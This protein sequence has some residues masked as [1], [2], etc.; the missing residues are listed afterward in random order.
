MPY[1]VTLVLL[2]LALVWI[3]T[4]A[5]DRQGL[6][7]DPKLESVASDG[8]VIVWESPV[9]TLGRVEYGLSD[10]LGSSVSESEAVRQHR[11]VLQG[12]EP[13]TRYYFR[14]VSG[15]TASRI[16][17]FATPPAPPSFHVEPYLQLP[18]P[19]SVTIMWETT[20][21]LPG[22]VEYG[23]TPELGLTAYESGRSRLH[24]V[25]LTGLKPATTY[26]YRVVSGELA[27]GVHSFRSAPP[28]GTSRWRMALYGDSRSNPAVHRKVVEQIA[29]HQVDIIVHT[30]DIVANG[31]NYA[32]WR[33]EWFVP[34]QP[35]APSV[36]WISTIGNHEADAE[37]Y[38]S[39][40]AL[41]GNERFFA[42]DFANARFFCLD[43]NAWIEKGRDSKQYQWLQEALRQPRQAQWAFAVFHHPL[44][45]GHRTRPINPLRWDWAPLL[46]D[47]EA[48]L[49]G[50]LT[51]HDHFYARCFPIGR[52][53]EPPSHAPLFLTSAGGGAPL[54]PIRQRDY[55]A[56]IKSV[57]HFVLFEFEDDR[58]T[59]SAIDI[60]GQVF[61]RHVLTKDLPPAHLL[62]AY[63]VEEFKEFL[64]KALAAMPPTVIQGPGPHK[65]ATSLEVPT[66]FEVPLSGRLLWQPTD[67]WFFRA[68]EIPFHLQPRQTLRIPLEAVVEARG[69][70]QTPQLVIEFD[71]GRFRN[72][73]VPVFPFKL[74][75][76]ATVEARPGPRPKLDG[77]PD[78]AGW[79]AAPAYPLVAA[80]A[81]SEPGLGGQVRFL[82]HG[83]MLYVAAVLEDPDDR[84]QVR[85]PSPTQEPSRLVLSGEHFR[86]E[87]SD[88]K[89]RWTLAVSPDNV[90]YLSQDGQQVP[91][92]WEMRAAKVPGAWT[93]ELAIPLAEL[94]PAKS[95]R[96]NAARRAAGSG[97]QVELRPAF[98]LGSSPD[99]LPDWKPG[100]QAA[101][102]A[103]LRFPQ[104]GS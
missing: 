33:R 81:G 5:P 80:T 79:E 29:R 27:S 68:M 93:A 36:P 53:T 12:L 102:L 87:L 18:Y 67:G 89:T 75:G 22:R 73:S 47:P 17:T 55:I 70:A 100:G 11:I 104:S 28:L 2:S 37:N 32:S 98:E 14:A 39:Y 71:P 50:V 24:Q 35:I 59:L 20:E 10:R 23:T 46:T 9:E 1:V 91:R 52:V 31:K 44:F 96:I 84:V 77:V 99:L 95:W 64:R 88:G 60:Q 101:N 72:R 92:D 85:S 86:V 16:K 8:A 13:G 6:E 76:P 94:A 48:K 69:L 25:R 63:E 103:E 97:R 26:Y 41:P 45:S 66:R 82:Q 65:I 34:L 83:S 43:S 30:G 21:K 74:T 51:G 7:L 57:Y 90:R 54:Y 40:V 49:D 62:C 61:D 3:G 56:A 58:V 4:W 38:F 78:E 15:E 42:F 19:D